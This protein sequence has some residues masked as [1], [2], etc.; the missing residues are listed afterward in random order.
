MVLIA[1]VVFL[2]SS[3]VLLVLGA[4]YTRTRR[5]GGRRYRERQRV[6]TSSTRWLC[7]SARPYSAYHNSPRPCGGHGTLEHLSSRM[8]IEDISVHA[9]YP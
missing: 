4:S 6:A 2:S 7:S 8:N 9:T 3:T 1:L 5:L